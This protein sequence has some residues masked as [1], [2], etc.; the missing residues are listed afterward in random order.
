M[1]ARARG[2]EAE[3]RGHWFTWLMLL[4]LFCLA[5][6]AVFFL[7]PASRIVLLRTLV[8]GL[9]ASCLAV[10]LGGAIAWI[11]AARGS[12][13]RALLVATLAL[14]LLPMI[15]HVSSW[16]SA[17]GKLGWITLGRGQVLQ[18]IVSGWFAAI[19]IHG[20]AATPQVAFLLLVYGWR[21]GFHFEDQAR[22]EASAWQ[23]FFRLTLP[24]YAPIL[25]VAVA[26]VVISCAREIAVTDLYQVETL[27][28][29]VYLG[30]SLSSNSMVGIWSGDQLADASN[31]DPR[32]VIVTTVLMVSIAAAMAYSLTHLGVDGDRMDSERIDRQKDSTFGQR[33]TSLGLL[34]LLVAVPMVNTIARASFYVESV[35]GNAEQRYDVTRL[36]A[37]V[38][39]AMLDYREELIW[40]TLIAL[41]AATVSVM[42]S[43]VWVSVG[44][45]S[46]LGRV[47]FALALGVC[48]GLPGPVVGNLLSSLFS[49]IRGEWFYWLTDYT[50]FGPVVASVIFCLPVC[51]LVV[52]F[53]L[54]R[55]TKSTLES[56]KLDGA[57][58]WRQIWVFGVQANRIALLGCWLI[59]FAFSF[60]ELAA[61]QMVRPAG[62][63]TVS[64]KML[65]DLHAGVNELTAGITIVMT[66]AVVGFSLI[67][68]S[69]IRL[70]LGESG[71]K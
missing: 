17:F 13:A 43:V 58:Y 32:L 52:W 67:G 50:I 18:P 26:W 24:R 33:L 70:N 9:S 39:R 34:L 62:M 42:V 55:T 25:A 30:Y 57:G 5:V 48:L 35:D 3:Q 59:C 71:R 19:W 38:S 51:G 65:G 46:K 60:G 14:L 36:P 56:A 15:V 28:E 1:S 68:W 2:S 23:V 22:T 4:L 66:V 53:L 44:R 7:G 10:P 40:S 49:S 45:N 54:H 6:V 27:A 16:D 21:Y 41:T 64:R 37:V 12:M 61:S 69:L 63:D 11:C 47:V 29:Q 31:L 20:I 8:L